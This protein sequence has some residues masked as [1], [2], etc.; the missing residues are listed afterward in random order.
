MY[1]LPS[2][3]VQHQGLRETCAAITEA[4]IAEYHYPGSLG[5]LDNLGSLSQDLAGTSLA[6]TQDRLS[7]EFIYYH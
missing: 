3:P 5:C 2:L 4:S 7:P 1:Q 6:E